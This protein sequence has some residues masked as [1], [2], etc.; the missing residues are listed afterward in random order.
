MA[1][2]VMY[3]ETCDDCGDER[4]RVWVV[5]TISKGAPVPT[6]WRL[7]GRPETPSWRRVERPTRDVT[8]CACDAP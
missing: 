6:G 7:Q 5:K 4:D 2:H 3:V 8:L 1:N